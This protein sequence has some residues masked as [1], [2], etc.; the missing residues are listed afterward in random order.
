MV[1]PSVNLAA[2]TYATPLY[3][4]EFSRTQGDIDT[5]I[6]ILLKNFRL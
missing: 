4:A 6:S 1:Y 5:R 2:A 3:I